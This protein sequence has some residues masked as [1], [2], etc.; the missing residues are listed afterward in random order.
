VSYAEL[1]KSNLI[2]G[3]FAGDIL[4]GHSHVLCSAPFAFIYCTAILQEKYRSRG[5]SVLA[6]PIIDFRQELSSN[7]EIET[8]VHDNFPQAKF[9]MFSLSSLEENPVYASIR[10]QVPEQPPK[11]NFYKYLVD[12][13]GR[14]VKV[15]DHQTNPLAL[16]DDIDALLASSRSGGGKLVTE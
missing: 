8:W 16:I 1:C 14:V 6:F 3:F 5:F 7:Q 15:F 10:K 9:P 11:W 12:G 2:P 13:D 4:N